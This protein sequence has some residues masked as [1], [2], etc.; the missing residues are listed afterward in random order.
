[1]RQDLSGAP[2]GAEPD[3]VNALRE[4]LAFSQLVMEHAADAVFLLNEEGRTVYANPA[5]ERMFGWSRAELEGRKLH[6]VVHDRHPDGTPYP[7][8]QCPLGRVFFSG[9]SLY[10]HEDT[11]FHRDGRPV[12]VACSNAPVMRD[13]TVEGGVLIVRDIS[14][15]RRAQQALAESEAR[16]RNMADSAPVMMGVT[17]ADG[18]CTYL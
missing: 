12:P 17:D 3:P 4:R 18:H 2:V 1:M 10:S 14:D 11:F 8:E 9:Q 13:G 16:F 15:A 6:D 7:M 5:A